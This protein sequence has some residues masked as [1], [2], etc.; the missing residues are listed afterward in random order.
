MGVGTLTIVKLVTFNLLGSECFTHNINLNWKSNIAAQHNLDSSLALS[1]I[2]CRYAMLHVSVTF[3]ESKLYRNSIEPHRPAF[4]EEAI[5]L[6]LE[7]LSDK[8]LDNNNA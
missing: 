7:E 1:K 5:G 6:L 8:K 3:F 2:P 4:R